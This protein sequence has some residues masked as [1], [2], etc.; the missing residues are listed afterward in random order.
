MHILIVE[1]DEATARSIRDALRAAGHEARTV[2]SA[3]AARTAL[4]TEAFDLAIVDIGLP[5]ADGLS[6]VRHLRKRD[7]HVPVLILTARDA[8]TDRVGALDLGAD[9]YMVKPFALT[10]LTARCRALIRRSQ[11]AASNEVRINGLD[12]DFAMARAVIDG[13]PIA[14]TRGEW[15]MLERLAMQPGRIVDK[16]V[17]RAA[18]AQDETAP[19]P[20]AVEACL[21]RL[22]AKLGNAVSITALRGLGY[23]L[24]ETD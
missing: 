6:L 22:R 13:R 12:I 19:T 5:G 3:E 8:I 11:R 10:E 17:L 20:H 2:V 15:R 7:M 21:S 4:N 23:R 9:D 24:D 16:E 1:D 18:L 14:L